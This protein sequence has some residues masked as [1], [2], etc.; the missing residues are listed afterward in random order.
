MIAQK[1]MFIPTVGTVPV[2]DYDAT[3]SFITDYIEFPNSM[4]DWSLQTIFSINAGAGAQLSIQVSNNAINY[5]PFSAATTNV[6]LTIPGNLIIYNIIMPVRY[7]RIRYIPGATLGEI[8]FIIS[9]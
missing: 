5:V 8:S 6:D 2:F 9:K 1:E 4:K 3:N 7:M